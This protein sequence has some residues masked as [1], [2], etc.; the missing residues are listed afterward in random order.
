MLQ[1]LFP[2]SYRH[3]YLPY[4]VQTPPNILLDHHKQAQNIKH[5]TPNDYEEQNAPEGVYD[6]NAPHPTSQIYF[7]N[8]GGQAQQTDPYT[9]HGVVQ[10]HHQLS[11]A[12]PKDSFGHQ[13]TSGGQQKF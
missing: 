3:H 2:I 9:G 13:A 7:G 1:K 10:N 8:Q 4:G 6:S 11:D 5:T 12:T